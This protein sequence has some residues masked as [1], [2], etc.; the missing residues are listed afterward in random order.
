MLTGRGQTMAAVGSA[1]GWED[2]VGSEEGAVEIV[3]WALG[4]D[5]EGDTLGVAD[6]LFVG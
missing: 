3:G 1:L 5:S 4:V 2:L 6:M